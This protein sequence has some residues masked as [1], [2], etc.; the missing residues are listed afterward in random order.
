MRLILD[1]ARTVDEAITLL[2][3]YHIDFGD[4]PPLHYLIADAQG[5]S[6]VIEFI[7]ARMNVLRSEESWQVATNFLISGKS[8]EAAKALCPRYKRAY[9]ALQQAGGTLTPAGAMAVLEDVSQAN[10]MW[11]VVYSLDSGDIVVS[12]GRAYEQVYGF[13]LRMKNR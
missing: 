11:S 1:F 4:G 9:D 13:K 3:D 5:N 8:P 7:D 6:A 2:G 10:T 12:M